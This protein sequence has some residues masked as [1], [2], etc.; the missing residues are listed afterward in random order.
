MFA[1]LILV[2]LLVSVVDT[3][4]LQYSLYA[5]NSKYLLLNVYQVKYAAIWYV[6]FLLVRM[7]RNVLVLDKNYRSII[8]DILTFQYQY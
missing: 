6:H 1:L 8:C 5:P 4:F 3:F 7:F 2:V